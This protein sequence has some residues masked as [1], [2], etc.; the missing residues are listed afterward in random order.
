VYPKKYT[1]IALIEIIESNYERFWSEH[2]QKKKQFKIKE[3]DFCKWVY[4][5]SICCSKEKN[6]I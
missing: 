2:H 1:Y 4:E 3:V 6:K 5:N